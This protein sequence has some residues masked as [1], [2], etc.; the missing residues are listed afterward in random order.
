MVCIGR[1]TRWDYDGNRACS[2]T[3]LTNRITVN[4]WCRRVLRHLLLMSAN[5]SI[6]QRFVQV[7]KRLI[8]K[9][10]LVDVCFFHSLPQLYAIF[11]VLK[12]IPCCPENRKSIYLQKMYFFICSRLRR[13]N[14]LWIELRRHLTIR[15]K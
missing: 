6:C 9:R 12:I 11:K 8:T 10:N 13:H 1:R 2:N 7:N 3:T 15:N 14:K 4:T 5:M